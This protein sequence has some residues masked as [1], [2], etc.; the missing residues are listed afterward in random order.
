MINKTPYIFQSQCMKILFCCLT[1][2]IQM[3]WKL[4]KLAQLYAYAWKSHCML[5]D[6]KEYKF[7]VKSDSNGGNI[8]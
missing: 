6:F 1:Q 7:A 2:S 5:I 4:L 8:W 3:L